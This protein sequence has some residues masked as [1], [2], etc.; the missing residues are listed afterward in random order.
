MH[1]AHTDDVVPKKICGKNSVKIFKRKFCKHNMIYNL[2]G[3][4]ISSTTDEISWFS[5]EGFKTFRR[6]FPKILMDIRLKEG[7]F[8]SLPLGLDTA[9]TTKAKNQIEYP[10]F[11]WKKSEAISRLH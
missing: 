10:F 11:Y 7:N 4:L 1:L 9:Q 2:K 6:D 8:I 3:P 5:K